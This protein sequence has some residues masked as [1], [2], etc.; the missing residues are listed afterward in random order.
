MKNYFYIIISLF[1]FSYSKQSLAQSCF[2]YD[3]SQGECAVA[4]IICDPDFSLNAVNYGDTIANLCQLVNENQNQNLNQNQSMNQN[5]TPNQ[6]ECPA[7]NQIDSQ[8]ICDLNLSQT[9]ND[10]NSLETKFNETSSIL[11]ANISQVLD[12]KSLSALNFDSSFIDKVKGG[13]FSEIPSVIDTL[14]KRTKLA[15]VERDKTLRSL[16]QL[17]KKLKAKKK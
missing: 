16:L 11:S 10:L 9:Q 7:P 3:I 8:S 13:D 4:D 1:L 15:E 12:A 14:K 17:K 2:T 5:Q 6:I